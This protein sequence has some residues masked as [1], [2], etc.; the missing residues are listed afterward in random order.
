MPRSFRERPFHRQR[1]PLSGLALLLALACLRHFLPA[2]AEEFTLESLS[3]LDGLSSNSVFCML[4]DQVGYLWIGTTDGLNRYD[5]RKFKVFRHRAND[6]LS[7]THN[8]VMAL[9]QDPAGNIWVGTWGGGFDRFD[10][11]SETFRHYASLLAPEDSPGFKYV[12]DLYIPPSGRDSLWIGTWS[13]LN[14]F[15]LKSGRIDSYRADPRRH[16]SL[17]NDNI[18]VTYEDN[19]GRLWIG[20]INGLQRFMPGTQEFRF[21]PFPKQNS[22]PS[23][24]VTITAIYESPGDPGILWIGTLGEGLN[25]FEPGSGRWQKSKE[26]VFGPDKI[27]MR[28][29]L[30]IR[31]FPGRPRSLLLGTDFGVI[32][33]AKDTQHYMPLPPVAANED[34]GARDEVWSILHDRSGLLWVSLF[35]S[36][37][38]K[39]NAFEKNLR[40]FRLPG[41]EADTIRTIQ[42]FAEDARGRILLSDRGGDLLAHGGRVYAYDRRRELLEPL[43]PHPLVASGS[44][45][46]VSSIAVTPGGDTWYGGRWMAI[47]VRPDGK[48]AD[49][50]RLN[51]PLSHPNFIILGSILCMAE[52]MAGRMWLGTAAGVCRFDPATGAQHFFHLQRKRQIGLKGFYIQDILVDPGGRVWIATENGLFLVRRDGEGFLRFGHEDDR[53]DSLDDSHV[54]DLCLDPS[55]RLWVATSRGIDMAVL[56]GQSVKFRHFAPQGFSNDPITVHSLLADEA[57]DIWAATARG[58]ARLQP[59]TGAFSFYPDRQGGMPIEFLDGVCLRTRD[60]ELFFGGKN[61][62]YSFRPGRWKF[63]DLAPAIVLTDLWVNNQSVPRSILKRK[64]AAHPDAPELTLSLPHHRNDLSLE[65]AALDFARPERNQYAYRLK[66]EGG[67]WNYLGYDRRIH[68]AGL[69]PGRYVLQVKGANNDGVWNE[70]GLSL[71]IRIR[72]PFWRTWWFRGILGLLLAGL[73]VAWLRNRKKRMAAKIRTQVHIDHFC[74][75]FGVSRREQEIIEL[76]LLGRSNKEIEDALFIAESTVRNHIYS[77]YQKLDVR[78]RLQL[79]SLFKNY[80]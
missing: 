45:G 14:R 74:R 33:F 47:R 76:L 1:N 79:I 32:Q 26:M 46:R 60:G 15:W 34:S 39:L 4:Q 57:G 54:N 13:G 7:L 38:T 31:D 10:P 75:H 41:I 11:G 12:R 42:S 40:C 30:F 27:V 29:I 68:L 23:V 2:Q 28:N 58:I 18:Q 16:G 72:P 44:L 37:V 73:L 77:I 59:D 55:G 49:V 50:F 65:F 19:A 6:P 63:N 35:G 21:Y 61:G 9:C 43:W 67:G 3:A 53:P 51:P 66:G 70:K 48:Q 24:N 78:N 71:E 52:D 80:R 69:A 56:A 20:T 25:R 8:A 62:F 64:D 5:G 22:N 17:R 36:G